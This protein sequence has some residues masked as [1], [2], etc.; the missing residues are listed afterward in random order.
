METDNGVFIALII[1]LF[2]GVLFFLQGYDK[3]FR[4]KMSGV[5][6]IF[7]HPTLMR[8]IPRWILV[9]SVYLTSYVELIGGLFLIFGLFKIFAL[10]FLGIDLLIAAIAFTMIE[11][12]WD[13]RHVFPR[14]LLLLIALA[15]PAEWDIISIDWFWSLFIA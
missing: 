9:S 14:F 13:M 1:R 10:Y 4:V 2:L 7:E 3:V 8:R 12:M 11:P 15:I 5:I 6:Q